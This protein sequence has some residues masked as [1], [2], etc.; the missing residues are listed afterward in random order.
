MKDPLDISHEISCALNRGQA[1]VALESSVLAHGLPSP[2]NIETALAMEQ[3]VQEAGAVPATI[4]VI[5]GK[6]RVGLSHEEIE[7]LGKGG[8][9]KLAARDLPDACA[10][11]INGGTTVS[12]TARIAAAVGIN[13]MATGGIGGVHRGNAN[14]IS[15]DLWEMTRTPIAIVCSGPKAVLD[16]P[17]TAEWLESHSVPVYG[18]KTTIL[19][20][21]YAAQTD[22]TIPGYDTI[23]KL[24]DTIKLGFG[25]MGVR[26]SIMV[27]V[28]GPEA[29]DVSREVEE[30]I[31]QAEQ[32]QIRGKQL[33]PWLLDK[34][35]ELTN[36]RSI[37]SNVALLKNNAQIAAELACALVN[38]ERRRM[39]FYA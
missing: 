16:V 38:E 32:N 15:A 30:A 5:D 23:D 25:A 24:A 28:P 12:A 31:K 27:A 36:G 21:F 18:F 7:I 4:G 22:I 2:V 11:E 33:T 3:N 29:F 17:A 39:G 26:S 20:A 14:D 34:I 1:V 37:E 8:T 10:T 13:V 35:A 6:I 9:A 19:P